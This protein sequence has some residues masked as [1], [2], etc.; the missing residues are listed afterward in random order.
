[1]NKVE[2]HNGNN[3]NENPYILYKCYSSFNDEKFLSYS[4]SS[5]FLKSPPA[6][7]KILPIFNNACRHSASTPPGAASLVVGSTPNWPEI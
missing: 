4:L 5:P 2:I 3:P 1:M 6:A 7:F